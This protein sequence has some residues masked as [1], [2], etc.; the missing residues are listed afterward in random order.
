MEKVT[1]EEVARMIDG[2]IYCHQWHNCRYGHCKM[3]KCKLKPEDK[4]IDLVMETLEKHNLTLSDFA[5]ILEA[6]RRYFTR[7]REQ[8]NTLMYNIQKIC[9][10]FNMEVA[11]LGS[12]TT[13]MCPSE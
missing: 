11:L 6:Y 10:S 5:R 4:R 7:I 3:H 13:K 1:R 12:I 8:E 9:L 2:M